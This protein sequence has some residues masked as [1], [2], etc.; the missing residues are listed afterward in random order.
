MPSVLRLTSASNPVSARGILKGT[1]ES[2]I[3]IPDKEPI[4]A[5]ENRICAV[6]VL[7][8]IALPASLCH[9]IQNQAGREEFKRELLK[10]SGEEHAAAL[11]R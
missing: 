2:E 9:D 5:R 3:K 7:A 1:F 11:A 8:S 6:A 4:M 10:L